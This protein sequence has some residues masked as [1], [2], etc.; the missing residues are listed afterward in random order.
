MRT[1]HPARGGV[2]PASIFTL[3]LAPL[4]LTLALA[5]CGGD[6]GGDDDGA[7]T[8]NDDDGSSSNPTNGDDATNDDAASSDDAPTDDSGSSSADD[9]TDDSG[10]E[11]GACAD[12]GAG[13]PADALEIE[14]DWVDD[15][16]GTHAITA[17]SWTQT[18][19]FGTLVYAIASWDNTADTLVGQDEADSTWSKFQWAAAEDGSFYYCQT[20]FGAACRA[21]AEAAPDA[22]ATDPAVGGCGG[23]FPWTHLTPPPR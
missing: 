9:A 10:S 5:G 15:F 6:D 16:M 12:E 21:D 17:E 7:D 22:D 4:T 14:G 13:P 2:A 3:T 23:M 19:E 8:A 20:A 18:S 1:N 11:T